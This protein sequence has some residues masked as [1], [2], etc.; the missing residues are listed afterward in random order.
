VIFQK[1]PIE[2]VICQL[3][4]PPILRI[5]AAVPADFQDRLRVDFPNFREQAGLRIE[6]APDLDKRLPVDLLRQAIQPTNTKQYEFASDDGVWKVAL[7]R[8]FIS[9]TTT[10]YE[11]WG[12]F[13]ERLAKPLEALRTTYAPS[14][15]TRV[16]LRYIDVI[17]KTALG[18]QDEPWRSLITP[19]LIAMLG[20]PELDGEVQ[21]LE[22]VNEISLPDERGTA[23]IAGRMVKSEPD[24]ELCFMIDG[25]YY[26]DSRV[27][28]DEAIER[29]DFFNMQASRLIRW[30]VKPKLRKALG[31][32][33]VT[34]TK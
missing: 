4:F 10:R 30:I 28:I 7:T 25:D 31:A 18:L 16:G 34:G 22:S 8:T 24:K 1:N 13:R 11:R 29:L 27:E 33:E 12:E 14:Y 15:F 20:S 6:M 32:Q 19:N 17:R 23:R 9:L 3:R 26:I 21:G 2:E 5:E